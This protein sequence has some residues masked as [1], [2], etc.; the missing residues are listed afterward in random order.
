MD[1]RRHARRLSQQ[2]EASAS[3]SAC[4][5]ACACACVWTWTWMWM[6][7]C[8]RSVGGGVRE[9]EGPFTFPALLR[10]GKFP[11]YREVPAF[12]LSVRERYR[13]TYQDTYQDTAS[14]TSVHTPSV[15]PTRARL[16]TSEQH[17]ASIF[18][19]LEIIYD[20]HTQSSRNPS[21]QCRHRPTH[22]INISRSGGQ[23]RCMFDFGSFFSSGRRTENK[24]I[25]LLGYTGYQ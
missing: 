14:F 8:R 16:E 7:M 2:K 24:Y 6:W 23:P 17:L 12:A 20:G 13:D 19:R 11:A 18:H 25:L 5:C 9:R 3:A 15:S 1:S 21:T 10:V 4:A 22:A